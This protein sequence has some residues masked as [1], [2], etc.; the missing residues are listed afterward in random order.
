M[1]VCVHDRVKTRNIMAR[2]ALYC[3][4]YN[5]NYNICASSRLSSHNQ[6]KC[7]SE[8]KSEKKE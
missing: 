7:S 8:K 2:N 1:F 4:I 6:L 5:T 3:G